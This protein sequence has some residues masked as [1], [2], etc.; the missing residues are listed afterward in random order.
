MSGDGW[1]TC[2]AG[3]RHWRRFGAAGLLLRSAPGT[4]APL[5]LQLRAEWSHH[6][7]TWGLLGGVLDA[8]EMPVD[9]ALCESGE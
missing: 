5:G 6:G 1:T 3:H 2:A 8:A 4:D 7:G 9:G